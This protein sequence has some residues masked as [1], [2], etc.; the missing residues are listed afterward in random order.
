MSK[1]SLAVVNNCGFSISLISEGF[2]DGHMVDVEV[3]CRSYTIKDVRGASLKGWFRKNFELTLWKP[4]FIDL[5]EL[6]RADKVNSGTQVVWDGEWHLSK[7]QIVMTVPPAPIKEFDDG[8]VA[9]A[10]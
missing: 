8:M 3:T 4:R 10:M 6:L 5:Y 2:I 9:P 7:P 1:L